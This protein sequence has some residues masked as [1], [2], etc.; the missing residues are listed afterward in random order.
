MPALWKLEVVNA[1]L[2]A[3]R[4][5]R[6]TPERAEAFLAQLRGFAIEVDDGASVK[7]DNEIFSAWFEASN[8]FLRRC[9]F[10]ASY[11]TQA[12]IGNTG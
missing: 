5:G 9:L 6:I 2:K 1:L 7:A 4:Q 3:K 12:P 10:G 11:A 8:E